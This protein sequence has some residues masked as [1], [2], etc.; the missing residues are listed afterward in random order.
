[1]LLKTDIS[2]RS[3]GK[4]SYY[5]PGYASFYEFFPDHFNI[6]LVP[7]THCEAVFMCFM[8]KPGGKT[9]LGLSSLDIQSACSDSLRFIP[10]EQIVYHVQGG[11]AS[12]F[13]S[14]FQETGIME[15]RL[16]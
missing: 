10:M 16:E 12:R 8:D 1:M 11:K 2:F 14:Y 7:P 6:Y 13:L 5:K 9:K 4:T 3:P 15:T